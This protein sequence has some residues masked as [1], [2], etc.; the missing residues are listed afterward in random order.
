MAH[1]WYWLSHL[2]FLFSNGGNEGEFKVWRLFI[3][4]Q[5]ESLILR[6][7]LIAFWVHQVTKGENPRIEEGVPGIH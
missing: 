5:L 7:G 6:L 1:W 4:P 2:R 3:P